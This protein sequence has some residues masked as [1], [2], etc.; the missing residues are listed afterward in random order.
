MNYEQFV[1]L[2]LDLRIAYENNEP[3]A[4]T[5]TMVGGTWVAAVIPE[6]Q[7]EVYSTIASDASNWV[8]DMMDEYD[9][10]EDDAMSRIEEGNFKCKIVVAWLQESDESEDVE[11]VNMEE[12]K[13][14]ETLTLA[15]SNDFDQFISEVI[16]CE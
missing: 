4:F 12:L 2:S 5:E 10:S 3:F 1:K 16:G 14:F 15:L 9:I 13:T 6:F 8:G 11:E 7:Y